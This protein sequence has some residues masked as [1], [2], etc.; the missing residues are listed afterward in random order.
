MRVR[1][2]VKRHVIDGNIHVRSVVGVEA[3]EKNMFRDAPSLVLS[4]EKPG[5]KP[6]QVLGRIDG[7]QVQ[8][9][10]A[11][12][13]K[14]GIIG[15][16]GDRDS[17]EVHGPSFQSNVDSWRGVPDGDSLWLVSNVRNIQRVC[18]FRNA[19]F[20]ISLV[21]RTGVAPVFPGADDG[22]R[23]RLAV[24]LVDDPAF[25]DCLGKYG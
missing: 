22:F 23:Q 4:Q 14:G 20:K 21:I 18:L 7:P 11:N 12:R 1:D 10:A 3:P 25:N 8:V 19:Q 9:D 13:M 24:A 6:H 17:P 16:R 5:Y 2:Q 15:K